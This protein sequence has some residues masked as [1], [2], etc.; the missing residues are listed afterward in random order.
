MNEQN[1]FT[2][3]VQG[4]FL[5]STNKQKIDLIAVHSFLTN[6]YWSKGITLDKIKNSIENSLCFGVYYNSKQIGF[7][8]VVT[9][10]TLFGYIADVFILEEYRGR[11]LSKWLMDTIINYPSIKN[12]R[13]WMLAT[14]GAHGL[15]EKYGFEKISDPEKYMK[16]KNLNF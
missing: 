9:D 1:N 4:D 5:I 3:F 10:Y 2:E 11:G 15:Y 8:R 7:S 14:S 13:S 12:L 16:K 6:S